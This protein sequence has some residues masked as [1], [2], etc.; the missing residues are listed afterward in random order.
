MSEAQAAG[1]KKV[2]KSFG[3]ALP[4][5]TV[6]VFKKTP[7][8]DLRLHIFSPEGHGP[9]DKRPA[10]VFF[11]GGG[12][13]NGGP[14]QFFRHSLYLASRGM[15]AACAEYRVKNKH[16]T[17]P[18]ECVA[19]GKSAVRW[20][21]AHA[22]ELGID[23][24][25]LAAGGGSAGGH[26]AAATASLAGFDEPGEDLAVSS[27]PN[28]LALFNPVV[29]TGKTGWKGGVR[30]LGDRAEELSPWHHLTKGAPPAI[31]FHGSKDTTVPLENV[32]RYRD[33]LRKLGSRCELVVFDG[34]GHGFFNY[35]RQGNAAFR[36]TV[37]EMDIFL[38][39]IGY[40]SGEP[41]ME[42]DG[43]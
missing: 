4:G 33:T 3:R 15:V 21:R 32:Q 22:G 13:V 29:D 12:W 8:V 27:V 42:A 43:D 25:R 16:G 19:D 18:L 9:A 41:T 34:K 11:F 37:R 23:P 35:G 1:R 5:A 20:L 17:T 40:L 30:Q 2:S 28:A 6:R 38:T 14:G 26:V 31:I 10:I 39:S 24:N 7:Q 36:K